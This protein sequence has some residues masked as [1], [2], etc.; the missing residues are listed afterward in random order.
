MKNKILL[1]LVFALLF[2][3][4][5][6]T[7]APVAVSDTAME[8][9]KSAA[10]AAQA[11]QQQPSHLRVIFNRKLEERRKELT[12]KKLEKRAPQTTAAAIATA[13]K[14]NRIVSDI[15]KS[16]LLKGIEYYLE[17][18]YTVAEIGDIYSSQEIP[19]DIKEIGEYLEK[20]YPAKMLQELT[21]LQE[22]LS[23]A[24]PI[25]LLPNDKT[26]D[27]N[28]AQT[29][30]LIGVLLETNKAVATEDIQ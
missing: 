30:L 29:Y 8:T 27:F 9:I 21:T 20:Y 10:Q 13:F 7:A 23:A 15:P 26:V 28:V 17:Q 22:K 6:V 25:Y 5:S 18:T 2:T 4:V 12:A 1:F 16:V 14:D 3:V 19:A 24:S 11:T